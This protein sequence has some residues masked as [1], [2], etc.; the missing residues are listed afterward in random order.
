MH[1]V[2]DEQGVLSEQHSSECIGFM[3]D[4]FFGDIKIAQTKLSILGP[5]I[6]NIDVQT[7]REEFMHL[8]QM[9]PLTIDPA[10][11][12]YRRELR[13]DGKKPEGCDAKSAALREAMIATLGNAAKRFDDTP[14]KD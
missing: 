11:A 14:I 4:F 1:R 2:I 5:G 13:K 12:M 3:Y 10:I 7:A 6:P 9:A 8:L